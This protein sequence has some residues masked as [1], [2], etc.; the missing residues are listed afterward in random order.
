M[1]GYRVEG[2]F[3]PAWLWASA[4]FAST[5]GPRSQSATVGVYH[6]YPKQH[7]C[8]FPLKK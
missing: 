3:L 4:V 1:L 7:I 8:Y 2:K 5:P 6:I